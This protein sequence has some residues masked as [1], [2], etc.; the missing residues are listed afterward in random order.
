MK[1]FDLRDPLYYSVIY[2][3]LV[4]HSKPRIILQ[5]KSIYN[6]KI[7]HLTDVFTFFDFYRENL[8][9]TFLSKETKPHM[10]CMSC[11]SLDHLET[12]RY[13]NDTV[14]FLNKQGLDIYLYENIFIDLG[15]NKR[16]KVHELPD[17]NINKSQ[18]YEQIKHSV[19]GFES[20]E[21]NLEKI[22]CFEFESISR[23]AKNNNLTDVKVLTGDYNVKD[24]FQPKYP[25]IKIANQDICVASMFGVKENTFNAYQYVLDPTHSPSADK[26]TNKFLCFN[27]RY[28]AYRHLIASYLIGKSSLLSFQ[29]EIEDSPFEIF[30]DRTTFDQPL[31]GGIEQ[32]L[33]FDLDRWK[34][35]SVYSDIL[36]GMA[37]LEMGPKNIDV[38]ITDDISPEVKPV[39]VEVYQRCFLSV[40]TEEK[41][42][43]PTGSFSEKTLNAIKCFSPFLLVAPPNTLKYLK[44]YGIKTFSDF[45]DESYDDEINHE[46]RLLKIMSV[47]D[48]INSKDITELKKIYNEMIPI[49]E[50]N[51]RTIYEIKDRKWI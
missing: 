22:Y 47:I 20:T 35:L 5:N 23:F 49:L 13:S 36:S 14:E 27:R 15:P 8:K 6:E 31:W 41:Y 19:T 7:V 30:D 24:Y 18:A 17:M 33:W 37:E 46:K 11:A 44:D 25:D 4:K 38:D 26:I 39:P 45:W 50:H 43:R 21:E 10:I 29:W 28:T 16:S 34:G 51:Y 3:H 48:H 32:Y 12:L 9:Q 40:V 42:T 1:K 2:E